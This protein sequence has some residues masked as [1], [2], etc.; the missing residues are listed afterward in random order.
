M[1]RYQKHREA[2]KTIEHI[3]DEPGKYLVIH[4]SCESFY[5][6]ED[7]RTPRIT[8]IAVRY[9]DSA[10]TR[11][12]SI[13]K[14]AEQRRIPIVE[15]EERYSECEKAMLDDFFI[16]VNAHNKY[17]WLHW[18]MRDENYGFY[19]IERRY[20]VLEGEP[21]TIQDDRKIDISRLFKDYYGDK[22]IEHP[23][24]E[25]LIKMNELIHP[26]FLSGAEEA[27]AFDN[28][29]YIKLHKST[30]RKV[31]VFAC[32]IA[33]TS[34]RTLKTNATWKRIYGISLQGL[35]DMA[36]EK[37]WFTVVTLFLGAALGGILSVIVR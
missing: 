6:K 19:A 5:D 37:W 17:Y 26:D 10:Q 31:G 14:S 28:K 32:F 24:I 20:R 4:Y 27:D 2:A 36:K 1:A 29:Q 23:N 15:I 11:S 12:F 9:F 7:G 13:H 34:E 16:F 30:L 35:F 21:E 3:M 22:Y 33:M 25:E 8:S 18:N